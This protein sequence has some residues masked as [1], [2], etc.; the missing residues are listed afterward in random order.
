MSAGCCNVGL[1]LLVQQLAVICSQQ[2]L[3]V[4]FRFGNPYTLPIKIVPLFPFCRPG[5]QIFM[6]RL[7]VAFRLVALKYS[8][9]C[10]LYLLLYEYVQP[11]L[12]YIRYRVN[13]NI[14]LYLNVL[15]TVIIVYYRGQPV[16]VCKS[17]R[18]NS[19]KNPPTPHTPY[20]P[21]CLELWIMCF[22]LRYT[23]QASDNT[24]IIVVSLS[25]V[26]AIWQTD[27]Q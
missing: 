17:Q 24:I 11:T 25:A 21:G 27:Q 19:A 18:S 4:W 9:K 1:C 23:V 13:T 2:Q 20:P 14:E 7:E 6:C 16:S 22:R 12:Y 3:Y 8:D 5:K 15:C 10:L 26:M